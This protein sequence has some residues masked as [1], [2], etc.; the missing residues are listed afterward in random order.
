MKREWYVIAN[1]ENLVNA[2]RV[3]VFN[4]FGTDT[5]KQEK[6]IDYDISYLDVNSLSDED[7]EELDSVLSYDESYSIVMENT[8]KQTHKKTKEIRYIMDDLIFSTIIENLNS[9]MISNMLNN[10]VNKG[11]LESGF[12]S[13]S[14]EFVF[15]IKDHENKKATDE[16]EAS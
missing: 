13:D 12:D 16:P 14:N 8:K 9:R 2:A 4:S 1:I 6:S 5:K 15:W 10:L 11:V 7:R 3:L